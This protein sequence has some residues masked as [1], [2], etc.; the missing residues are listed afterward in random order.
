MLDIVGGTKDSTAINSKRV[1]DRVLGEMLEALDRPPALHVFGHVHASMTERDATAGGL[2]VV[3]RQPSLLKQC[4]SDGVEPAPG[5]IRVLADARG[6][7][8]AN[9]AGLRIG[10]GQMQHHREERDRAPLRQGSLRAPLVVCL[11]GDGA[12]SV[13]GSH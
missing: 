13:Q 1:G 3:H 12:I 5:D 7:A 2:T 8:Y 4:G 11:D 10:A 6:C 9:A